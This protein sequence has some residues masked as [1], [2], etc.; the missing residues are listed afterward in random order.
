VPSGRALVSSISK[1]RATA[2]RYSFGAARQ[3]QFSPSQSAWGC[4]TRAI[5]P[6]T[7]FTCPNYG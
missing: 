5:G 1:R 3:I 4:Q 6:K 7:G 2:L